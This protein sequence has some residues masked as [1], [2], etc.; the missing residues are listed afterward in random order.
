MSGL[1]PINTSQPLSEILHP[2]TLPTTEETH[3]LGL[4]TTGKKGV[5]A[6]SIG[7]VITLLN[8]GGISCSIKKSGR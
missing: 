8:Q 2:F 7:T 1:E 5:D 3:F 6:T 4:T